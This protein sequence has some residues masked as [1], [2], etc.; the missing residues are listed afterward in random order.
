MKPKNSALEAARRFLEKESLT[1]EIK[2]RNRQHKIS[3][4]VLSFQ[5]ALVEIITRAPPY[6]D[7]DMINFL[8]LEVLNLLRAAEKKYNETLDQ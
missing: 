8:R 7:E 2:E 1:E 4:D 6:L 3:A 5:A